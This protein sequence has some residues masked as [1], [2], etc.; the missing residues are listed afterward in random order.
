MSKKSERSRKLRFNRFRKNDPTH[1]VLVAVSRWIKAN[2]GDVMVI[3]GIEIQDWQEGAWKFRVGV[4]CLG[5][6]PVK[7]KE[8]ESS[9]RGRLS[10][11]KLI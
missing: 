9:K 2:G 10:K 1:N 6:A 3:G 11:A 7:A 8:T 5:L 4:K